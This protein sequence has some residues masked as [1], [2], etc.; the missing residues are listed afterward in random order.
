M[1]RDGERVRGVRGRAVRGRAARGVGGRGRAVCGVLG[2]GH[3]VHG[4]RRRGRAVRGVLARRAVHDETVLAPSPR[5]EPFVNPLV[6]ERIDAELEPSRP[7]KNSS[8]ASTD[9]LFFLG[10]FKQTPLQWAKPTGASPKTRGS[11]EERGSSTG[12]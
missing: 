10:S 8:S 3:T 9:C 11:V 1:R 4:V 5:R 6:D 12:C 2:R 7:L